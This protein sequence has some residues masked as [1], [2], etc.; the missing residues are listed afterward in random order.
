MAAIAREA[1]GGDAE[2]I[3]GRAPEKLPDHVSVALLIDVLQMMP[4]GEQE[5]LL[6]AIR[7]RMPDAGVLFVREADADAAVGFVRIRIGNRLKAILVGN[8]AQVFHFRGAREWQGLFARLGWI[9]TSVPVASSG[10][11]A[12][13]LFRLTKR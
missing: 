4:A 6:A 1:L 9:V 2:I 7:S 8:W 12:N 5:G 13:V 10:R 11:F 3:S